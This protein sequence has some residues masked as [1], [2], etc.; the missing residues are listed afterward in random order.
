MSSDPGIKK[1]LIVSQTFPPDVGIGGRRWAKFAKYFFR[2]GWKVEVIAA[3]MKS[4]T[5]SS[6]TG[7]V[8][9]IPVTRYAHRFPKILSSIPKTLKSKI[10]YRLALASNKLSGK[11]TPYDRA[12]LD[13]KAFRNL[14][15]ERMWQYKPDFVIVTGAPFNLMDYAA[16]MRIHYPSAK[17][18]ADWRDPW[19]GDGR[20]GYSGLSGS[21]L[22]NE[23]DKERRVVET[24]DFLTSPWPFVL[25]DIS[26]RHSDLTRKVHLLP[27]N[28]DP[29]DISAAFE[30]DEDSPIDLVYGGNLYNSFQDFLKFLEKFAF[31]TQN[32]VRIYTDA[33]TSLSEHQTN[34]WFQ[35]KKP[36]PSRDFFKKMGAAQNLLFLIPEFNKDGFPTKVL[37]Y[38]ATGKRM[39]AVGYAGE[40]SRLIE[41]KGLGIFVD[42][43]D[44]EEKFESILNDNTPLQPDQKWIAQ[45]KTETI[46]KGLMKLL[47]A[48]R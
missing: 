25:Q 33:Q 24:F 36:L 22:Q 3:D 46:T 28:W 16:Q 44:V 11:G 8:E 39:I 12:L 34:P 19:I 38:A 41:S 14:F 47:T 37:E 13:E 45:H 31:R 43:T 10:A 48:H 29:D 27:H 26:K 5:T 30:S 17:F 23:R 7:D 20:Y 15:S 40:L 35:I 9:G 18:L 1:V 2:K 42:L 21:R 32:T 6:W 4:S